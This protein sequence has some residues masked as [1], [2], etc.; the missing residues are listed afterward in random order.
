MSSPTTPPVSGVPAGNW[1]TNLEAYLEQGWS[2]IVSTVQ[3][4][5]SQLIPYLDLA[6]Q[7]LPILAMDISSFANIITTAFPQAGALTAYLTEIESLITDAESYVSTA[8]G[9]IMSIVEA[10]Q[11]N[12]IIGSKPATGVQKMAVVLN[13]ISGAYPNIPESVHRQAIEISLGKI[14]SKVK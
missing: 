6:I 13:T 12:A 11:I 5:L 3:N 7:D 1:F 10:T 8:L 4:L 14:K 9:A 2:D